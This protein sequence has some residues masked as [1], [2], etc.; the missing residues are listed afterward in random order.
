M[1]KIEKE[2]KELGLSAEELYRKRQEQAL[3]ILDEF[4]KWLDAKIEKVPPKSLLGKA[5]NYTLNQWHRLVLYTESGLIMPDNNV[6]GNAIRPFVV[7]RKKWLFSC[8]PRAQV[9]V[10]VFTSNPKS[11][12][13]HLSG[14]I[15]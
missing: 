8:N 1:S 14:Q 7:G 9:P 10:L 13:S 2:A 4:K 5:I 11:S 12:M 15:P 3:P 6:V